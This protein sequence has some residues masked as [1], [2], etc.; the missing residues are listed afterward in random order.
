MTPFIKMSLIPF[1]FILV[2]SSVAQT[3]PPSTPAKSAA[4][5]EQRVGDI[6]R[7]QTFQL[8]ALEIRA[9]I[10]EPTLIYVLDRPDFH[11]P[12]EDA[13]VQLIPRI[14]LPIRWNTLP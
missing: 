1:A 12:F 3:R 10:H 8:D 7:G 13:P 4:A 5:L 11:V 2:F 9:K 6:T 14:S